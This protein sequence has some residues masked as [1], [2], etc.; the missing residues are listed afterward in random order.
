[1]NEAVNFVIVTVYDLTAHG[2]GEP[3]LEPAW[4]ET[5]NISESKLHNEDLGISVAVTEC[6]LGVVT[7]A[8]KKPSHGGLQNSNKHFLL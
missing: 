1:M 6:L 2:H 4:N 3:A 7:A 5:Y 8:T